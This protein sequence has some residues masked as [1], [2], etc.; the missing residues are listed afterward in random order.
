MIFIYIVYDIRRVKINQHVNIPRSLAASFRFKVTVF[1]LAT[2]LVGQLQAM[3]DFDK[4]CRLF[5]NGT[6]IRKPGTCDEYI[7]CVDGKGTYH[8]CASTLMFDAA[9]QSCVSKTDSLAKNCDNPCKGLDG[10]WVADPT[11][12][13]NYFY[14]DHGQTV[15]GH[16]LGAQHF[17]ESTQTCQ[18]GV[19]SLCVGVANICDILPSNA[20]FRQENDCNLYYECG[21]T[22]KHALKAC[23]SNLYFDVEQ[24]ECLPAKQVKCNAHSKT[25]K[26]KGP[27]TG[28]VRDGATCRGYFYCAYLGSVPDLNPAWLQCP[29]GTLFDDTLKICAK[30][31]SV[32]CTDNRCDGR[33]N[34]LVTSSTNNCHSY[35]ECADDLEIGYGTCVWD[36]F[37]DETLQS[38]VP[39]IIYD[40]CC[41][42]TD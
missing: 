42:G 41:D 38:C 23:K 19:D 25:D 34:M 1:A 28:F 29:P 3:T 20:K 40:K 6:L 36:Y 15:P 16:C 18:Y 4:L 10:L 8:F 13:Q 26:C 14:C 31:T 17:N 7:E 24:S 11:E 33:G 30:P 5:K 32:L 35:I 21:K 27:K 9:K 39:S 12:C 2:C 37:F 22:G